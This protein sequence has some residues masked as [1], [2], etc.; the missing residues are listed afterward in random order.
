MT[1]KHAVMEIVPANRPD[2]SI[3]VRFLI[4]SPDGEVTALYFEPDQARL[5][6]EA[7]SNAIWAAEGHRNYNAPPRGEVH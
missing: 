3:K 7:L 6:M 1:K 5:L 2:G 4:T